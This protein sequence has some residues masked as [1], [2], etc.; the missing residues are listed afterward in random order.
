M[1]FDVILPK[2]YVQERDLKKSYFAALKAGDYNAYLAAAEAG[3]KVSWDQKGLCPVSSLLAGAFDPSVLGNGEA[4]KLDESRQL[5]LTHLMHQDNIDVLQRNRRELPGLDGSKGM[6]SVALACRLNMPEVVAQLT[7]DLP[8]SYNVIGRGDPYFGDGRPLLPESYA[9]TC[10]KSNAADCLKVI[11]SAKMHKNF[12]YKDGTDDLEFAS[13]SGHSDM[14]EMLDG[15]Q[16]EY[17]EYRARREEEW[18]QRKAE[19]RKTSSDGPDFT[20]PTIM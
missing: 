17:D 12:S 1:F 11:L 6:N 10:V 13:A 19:E 14:R 3:A 8:A 9:R 5:I 16:V 15:Y 2:A 20:P 18:K 7:A 4:Q